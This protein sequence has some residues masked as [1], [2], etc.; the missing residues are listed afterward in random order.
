MLDI[1]SAARWLDTAAYPLPQVADGVVEPRP[2]WG[3]APAVIPGYWVLDDCDPI[4]WSV[5][6]PGQHTRIIP[7]ASGRVRVTCGDGK[8]RRLTVDALVGRERAA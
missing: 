5:R 3:D 8:R 6:C 1:D 4:V 7:D 2:E